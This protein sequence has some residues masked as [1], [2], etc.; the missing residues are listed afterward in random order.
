MDELKMFANMTPRVEAKIRDYHK[1]LAY[2]F[3]PQA[4]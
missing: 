1:T 3:T 4:A 2:V